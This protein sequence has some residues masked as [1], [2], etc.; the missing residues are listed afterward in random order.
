[1][2]L[3]NSDMMVRQELLSFVKKILTGMLVFM[4]FQI[5]ISYIIIF[6]FN[7]TTRR[8]NYCKHTLIW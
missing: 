2:K 4:Y 3:I 5:N 6:K 8:R 1:M 7:I